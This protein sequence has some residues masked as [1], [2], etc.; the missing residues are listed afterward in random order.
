MTPL[1]DR[2]EAQY[3]AS[4]ALVLVHV[5]AASD[6]RFRLT[7]GVFVRPKPAPV[8]GQKRSK[9]QPAKVG[10]IADE[11]KTLIEPRLERGGVTPTL[12]GECEIMARALAEHLAERAAPPAV[13]QVD[14]AESDGDGA[15]QKFRRSRAFWWVV[16]GVGVAVVAGVAV[17]LG[18][19]LTH[20]Q[21]QLGRETVL[22]GGH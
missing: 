22:L 2:T 15:L 4:D 7:G 19:G 14:T 1:M 5:T 12:E 10:N 20:H 21:Q 17:G 3:M 6:M 13:A 8:R 18:V 9:K 16:G 11:A